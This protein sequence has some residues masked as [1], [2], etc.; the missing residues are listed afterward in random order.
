MELKL[1]KDVTKKEIADLCM[2]VKEIVLL[3][4]TQ[5]ATLSYLIT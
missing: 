5:H 1:I 3:F 4:R 2:R